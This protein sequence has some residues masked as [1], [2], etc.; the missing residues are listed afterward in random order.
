MTVKLVVLKSGENLISDIKEGYD[1][2][3][4]IT[5]IFENPCT[6][7]VNGKYRISTDEGDSRD[8]MSISLHRWPSFSADKTVPIPVDWIVTAV[9][10]IPAVIKMYNQN[11]KEENDETISATEQSDS[12]LTD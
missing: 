9:E 11:V 2:E 6:I 4:L 1:E 12:G 10:P 3:K 7:K 8:Q 5:Y